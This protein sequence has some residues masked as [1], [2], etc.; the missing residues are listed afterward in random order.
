[1][2]L[3]T[4]EFNLAI[5][6]N[7]AV[8][9]TLVRYNLPKADPVVIKLYDITGALVKSLAKANSA[10]DGVITID[11]KEFSSGIYI[12]RINTRQLKLT[13]KLVVQK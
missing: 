8:N 5:T 3:N 10:K 4:D 11:T 1:M 13:R 7:P 6:P 2:K 12:L 9:F